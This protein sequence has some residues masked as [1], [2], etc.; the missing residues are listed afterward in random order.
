MQYGRGRAR[1][2]SYSERAGY[3]QGDNYSAYGSGSAQ[4]SSYGR[5]DPYAPSR[6]GGYNQPVVRRT[7]GAYST[8]GSIRAPRMN[9]RVAVPVSK[10]PQRHVHDERSSEQNVYY[11]SSVPPSRAPIP[12]SAPRPAPRPIRQAPMSQPMRSSGSDYR[13][14][15]AQGAYHDPVASRP[16]V[17]MRPRGSTMRDD[18]GGK[19]YSSV[20][21]KR[22]RPPASRPVRDERPRKRRDTRP[23]PLKRSSQSSSSRAKRN[24]ESKRVQE[25]MRKIREAKEKRD[26][27]RREELVERTRRERKKSEDSKKAVP[28][29][30]KSS[31]KTSINLTS[32]EIFKT[33]NFSSVGSASTIRSK[34]TK[35]S[36]VKDVHHKKAS[37]KNTK[38]D[39]KLQSIIFASGIPGRSD[40]HEFLTCRHV[41][42][43]GLKVFPKV[44]FGENDFAFMLEISEIEKDRRRKYRSSS[45]R[46]I[47][48]WELMKR[49]IISVRTFSGDTVTNP[50]PQTLKIGSKAIPII[51]EDTETTEDKKPVAEEKAGEKVE[52]TEEEKPE[53]VDAEAMEVDEEKAEDA[54]P[55]PIVVQEIPSPPTKDEEKAVPD[56]VEE[57]KPE[58]PVPSGGAIPEIEEEDPLADKK[59]NSLTVKVLRKECSAR[60]LYAKGLKRELVAR[61]EKYLEEKRV[62]I[63]A[64]K[65]SQLSAVVKSEEEMKDVTPVAAGF[66]GEENDEEDGDSD[67]ILVDDDNEGNKKAVATMET[68]TDEKNVEKTKGGG[69]GDMDEEEEVVEGEEEEEE[70]VEAAEEEVEEEE[71]VEETIEEQKKEDEE[72]TIVKETEE[73]DVE[74]NENNEDEELYEEEEETIPTLEEGG[75][76]EMEDVEEQ[77][78]EGEA[79]EEHKELEMPVI[80]IDNVPSDLVDV[81]KM[82]NELLALP[83]CDLF[84]PDL[85]DVASWGNQE[86]CDHYLQSIDTPM[87]FTQLKN[88]IV[89]A[90]FNT[91]QEICDSVN[92]IFNNAK[93][94]NEDGSEW[95]IHADSLQLSFNELFAER[96]VEKNLI[97]LD[98][99]NNVIYT[100]FEDDLLKTIIEKADFKHSGLVEKEAL[101]EHAKKAGDALVQKEDDHIR[102]IILECHREIVEKKKALRASMAPEIQDNAG[103]EEEKKQTFWVVLALNHALREMRLDRDIVS[104]PDAERARLLILEFTSELS[105]SRFE[106]HTKL[107]TDNLGKEGTLNGCEKEDIWPSDELELGFIPTISKLIENSKEVYEA[108]KKAM[109]FDELIQ[110][111]KQLKKDLNR[112][113]SKYEQSQANNETLKSLMKKIRDLSD[114][115][116]RM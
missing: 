106:K 72:E 18:Y 50:G 115:R 67:V 98:E 57:E 87:C 109:T 73:E 1:Q 105:A 52:A 15:D 86:N 75:D 65:Q 93:T 113:E 89:N 95:F 102:N 92:L 94:Y 11:N 110:S 81:C 42:H 47:C 61:L 103:A 33:N 66:P 111:N 59:M 108:E 5:E 116:A 6:S 19:E 4:Q 24:I 17:P 14:Y 38:H 40:G 68:T 49:D 112:L 13:S 85:R 63:E 77:E 30:E 58:E 41:D 64:Q 96:Q 44:R 83:H 45:H 8:G 53:A 21:S 29:R 55:E 48:R 74:M 62:R 26:K 88:D 76:V 90:V 100:K 104:A 84:V 23:P 97:Q 28:S 7:G 12:R 56:A 99:E 39:M 107:W 114:Y 27:K 25:D 10:T 78:G 101:A 31:S 71:K 91:E 2:G 37:K 22:P 20:R 36:R 34:S 32:S 9:T 80:E 82:V 3:S 51:L 60:G 16:R 69:A 54:V 43:P 35:S 70:N 79:M 46:G